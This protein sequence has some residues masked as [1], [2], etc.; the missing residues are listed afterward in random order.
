[1]SENQGLSKKYF[2]DAIDAIDSKYVI[3]KTPRH[4]FSIEQMQKDFPESK[5]VCMTRNSIDVV[6]SL[7]KRDQNFNYAVYQ[8]SN[9][10]SGCLNATLLKNVLLVEYED[11]V[12]DFEKTVTTVCDF[13]NL[14]Y[15]SEMKNYHKNPPQW[16]E[17]LKDSDHH[18]D[19]RSKQ[20]ALP[21][22]DGRG[23]FRDLISEEET[24]QIIFDCS[25]KYYD[26][27][28]KILV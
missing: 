1:M 18:L 3:E 11:L 26:L 24:N 7:F 10:L 16:F 19:R 14:L 17:K 5:F 13:L 9:D 23:M 25:D 12:T 28:R 22:F 4:L 8:C 21:I 2:I 20:M 6:A 27:T 15:N